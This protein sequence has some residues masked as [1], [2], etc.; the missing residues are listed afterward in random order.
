MAR[1]NATW[2]CDR[3]QGALANIGYNVAPDTIKNILKRHGTEPAP[4]REK[5]TSWKMF[6]KAHWEVMAAT[7][8]FTVGVVVLLLII[9]LLLGYRKLLKKADIECPP[10]DENQRKGKRGTSTSRKVPFGPHQA[11]SPFCT[12]RGVFFTHHDRDGYRVI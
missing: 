6:L 5:R 8:F 4:A 3:I 12:P 11:L 7:D 10:P 1:E 9:N 2:V